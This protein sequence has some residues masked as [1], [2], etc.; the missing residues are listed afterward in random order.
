ML[1][2]QSFTRKIYQIFVIV[3]CFFNFASVCVLVWLEILFYN[4]NYKLFKLHVEI[5]PKGLH[6]DSIWTPFGVHLESH[7]H[8]NPLAISNVQ[9]MD[10]GIGLEM[11]FGELCRL[12][13]LNNW[14]TGLDNVQIQSSG[15]PDIRDSRMMVGLWMYLTT[16]I[17]QTLPYL[18]I[19]VVLLQFCFVFFYFI[20]FV[21]LF[22]VFFS[23]LIHS[24][25][26]CVVVQSLNLYHFSFLGIQYDPW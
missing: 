26:C 22:Y 17:K 11:D 1:L 19:S 2:Q 21:Y 7:H 5:A 6:L 4:G 25:F 13:H 18:Q 24:G 16:I 8:S 9:S 14:T 23:K 10:M 20:V 3:F 15:Y 12:H